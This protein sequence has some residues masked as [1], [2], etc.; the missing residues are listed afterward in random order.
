MVS[1]FFLKTAVFCLALLAGGVS[2]SS[3]S[4]DGDNPKEGVANGME[5]IDLSYS[6]A[7][8]EEWYKFF[9][10]EINYTIG[11]TEELTENPDMDWVFTMSVPYA[12][13][14]SNYSCRVTAK[15]KADA[16]AIDAAA[17][18]DLGYEITANVSGTMKDGSTSSEFGDTYKKSSQKTA[19]A[20]EMEKYI[21][22]EHQ[23]AS[24]SYTY[25][26]ANK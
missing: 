1:K 19:P 26:P 5:K 13:D 21:T 16:P 7:L 17:T 8:S 14:M 12:S 20:A 18:Y 11:G 6:V 2:L 22:G 4:G 10:I 15:P 3:C 9:D 24:F 23:L 25:T